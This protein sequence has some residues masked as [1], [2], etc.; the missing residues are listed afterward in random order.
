MNIAYAKDSNGEWDESPRIKRVKYFHYMLSLDANGNIVGGHFYRDS[1]V[2]DMLWVPRRPKQGGRPGNESGNPY[3]NVDEVLAIWRASAPE[4]TRKK[5][6]TVDP[7][8]LD[9]VALVDDEETTPISEN[10]MPAETDNA[11]AESEATE[12]TEET[13]DVETAT[14]S[15]ETTTEGQDT[16]T[17]D[18]P[19]A[20][21]EADVSE[22][23]AAEAATSDPDSG[24][25]LDV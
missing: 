6:L 15:S 3:V 18:E 23:N 11:T 16:T 25:E 12:S 8:E 5:W 1:S 24:E 22:A 9:R 14:A 10:A 2:I 17:T 19:G 4:E 7:A 21:A 20:A 13:T